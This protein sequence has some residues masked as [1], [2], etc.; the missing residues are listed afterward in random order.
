MEPVEAR[1]QVRQK[2]VDV[3]EVRLHVAE[4]GAPGGPLVVLLHGFPEFWWSWRHQIGALADAGFHVIAPDLRGFHLSD[5]PRAVRAYRLDRL[6][7]DVAGLI[8]AHGAPRAAVV[9]HDWGANVAW[10]FAQ[11]YPSMI[12]HLA[13]INVPHPRRSIEDGLRS[14]SQL[15]KSWY[16][17]FFQ[18][19]VLPEWWLSKNDFQ[20]VRRFFEEDG[21]APADAERYVEAARAA[22]DNLRAGVNYY[23]AL[24]RQ[25]AAGRAPAWGRIDTPTLIVWGEKDR[26]IDRDLA[27]PGT[28]AVPHRRLEFIANA[29]HWVQY[30]APERV[31]EL[32]LEFL[33]A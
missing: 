8:D 14:L 11:R 5:K 21:M 30:D 18:L 12:T 19:P 17:F 25:V 16:I 15:R 4:A 13:I 10:M 22:G 29:S 32:L 3:G 26:Y 6:A 23:R 20:T 28:T 24:L 33:K 31:N 2:F 27:D 1:R 9:G 7:A